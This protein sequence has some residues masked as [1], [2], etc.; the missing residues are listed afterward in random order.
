MKKLRFIP[1]AL[2]IILSGCN[3][4]ENKKVDTCTLEINVDGNSTGKL[5]IAPYQRVES[6]EAYNELTI[7]DS[8]K[9]K[10]TIVKIDT[11]SAVR[12]VSISY[13]KKNYST[14]L[15]T[16]TGTYVL[17]IINDSLIVK[18]APR[19]EEYLKIKKALGIAK[20][21]GLKYKKDLT[22]EEANFKASFS[23]KLIAAIKEHPK[24]I[25]LAQSAY[26]QFWNTDTNT[27]D[28]VLNSFDASLQSSYFLEPLVERRKNLDLVTMGKPAPLFT[29]KSYDNKDVSVT[30][31]RGKYLLI[32]F[33]AY[34]CGPCIKGFPELREIREAY[35]EDQLAILS[36][37]TDKNYDKWINAVDKHKLPWTQ[38]IDDE[39][40]PVNIG[41][42]YAVVGIPHL[43]LISPEGNIVYKHDYHDVLTDEL[44]NFLK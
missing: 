14:E 37:S 30:D 5:T 28:Q 44:K 17:S 22:P 25:A 38:V 20:M 19:H 23:D 10:T 3:T 43:V 41:S 29:L 4:K 31:Y 35:S 11:V 34:W 32:D 8:I 13:N 36:I 7:T 26:T 18:G 40:L 2:A 21:E 27:L 33:W 1:V 12:K 24:N 39:K 15:F 16:G 42:K 9:S 6:M